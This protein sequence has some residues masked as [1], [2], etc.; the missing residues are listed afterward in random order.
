MTEVPRASSLSSP[1]F[2]PFSR[3]LLG[4]RRGRHVVEAHAHD[5]R[6]CIGLQG[7]LH[8]DLSVVIVG[9]RS[10]LCSHG[11]GGGHRRGNRRRA[12][13]PSSGSHLSFSVG[14]GRRYHADVG[15]GFDLGHP[16]WR[17]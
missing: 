5:R 3:A 6:L 17:V 16:F 11:L 14:L 1:S 13:S 9:G 7:D 12:V 2:R 8:R 15:T 4:A 10:G